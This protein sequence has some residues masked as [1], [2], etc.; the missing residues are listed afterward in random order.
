MHECKLCRRHTQRRMD[1][2]G[3]VDVDR[4]LDRC[5]Q[6]AE[7]LEAARISHL[8]FELAVERLLVA[9]LPGTAFL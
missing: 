4:L 5:S 7:R 2:L 6:F 3:I 1:T 9:I 8:D